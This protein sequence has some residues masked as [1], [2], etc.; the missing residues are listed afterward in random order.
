MKKTLRIYITLC[1]L[2]IAS[3]SFSQNLTEVKS[4]TLTKSIASEYFE[5]ERKVKIFIPKNYTTKKK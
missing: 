5:N 3:A 2:L 4:D 1:I